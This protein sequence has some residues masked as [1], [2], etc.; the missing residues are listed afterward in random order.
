MLSMNCRLVDLSHSHEAARS[1]SAG[2][3]DEHLM[4]ALNMQKYFSGKLQDSCAQDKSIEIEA[5]F[6]LVHFCFKVVSR[7]VFFI[8]FLK[9]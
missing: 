4:C 9:I 1:S 3:S 7:Q 6:T 5:A 2:T 8:V